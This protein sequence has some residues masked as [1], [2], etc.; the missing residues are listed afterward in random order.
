MKGME[1]MKFP[2]L[3]QFL[4]IVVFAVTTVIIRHTV[5][6]ESWVWWVIAIV[7]AVV[8]GVLSDGD[9]SDETDGEEE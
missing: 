5:K 9:D 7:F 1:R 4:W 3:K 8:Y 2:N 6:L